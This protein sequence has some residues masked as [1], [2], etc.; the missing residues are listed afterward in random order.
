MTK[1]GKDASAGRKH[2]KGSAS[3][4]SRPGQG[5]MNPVSR[6]RIH[7]Q[8]KSGAHPDKNGAP[9]VEQNGSTV[10]ANRGS[11][12]DARHRMLCINTLPNLGNEMDEIQTMMP[13]L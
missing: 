10:V 7:T 1:I 2:S 12:E 13:T 6:Y 9:P 8:D 3:V 4:V 5:A 11:D